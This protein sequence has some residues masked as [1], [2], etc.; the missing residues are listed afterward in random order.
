S[1]K[2][3]LY[4]TCNIL[5]LL[6][7]LV[8][9]V[10]PLFE[11][12]TSIVES[13]E[14]IITV[15]HPLTKYFIFMINK[16]QIRELLLQISKISV[17][18]FRFPSKFIAKDTQFNKTIRVVQCVLP[19]FSGIVILTY[20]LRPILHDQ[21]FIMK[22]WTINSVAVITI[23]L[24]ME[25]YLFLLIIPIMAG[26]DCL[27]LAFCT[28]LILHVRRLNYIFENLPNTDCPEQMETNLIRC[29][30]YHEL[31][32]STFKC[33]KSL[34]SFTFL[35]HYFCTLLSMCV[36]LY[37]MLENSEYDIEQL[38]AVFAVVSQFAYYTFPVE[39]ITSEFLDTSRSIYMSDWYNGNIASQKLTLTVMLKAQD[40]EHFSGGGIIPATVDTFSSVSYQY[41]H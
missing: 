27:Y 26:Y 12:D 23:V 39:E 3:T 41:F 29:I 2:L 9:V 16:E 22:T 24:A 37:E 17:D 30:K 33:L 18:E 1:R 35:F 5:I 14:G 15:V 20:L 21:M 11:D 36:E 7:L 10:E 32:L 19:F 28:G 40:N 8:F 25:Y 13:I 6:V 31:L 34:Y 4:R 38:A